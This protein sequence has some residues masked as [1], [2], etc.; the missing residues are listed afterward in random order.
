MTAL[1]GI[2]AQT[3]TSNKQ[4][5]TRLRDLH[6]SPALVLTEPA[7]FDREVETGLVLGR[8]ASMLLQRLRAAD[9]GQRLRPSSRRQTIRKHAGDRREVAD[10]AVDYAKQI[11]DRSLVGVD[12]IEICRSGQ[13]SF[14][15]LERKARCVGLP[16]GVA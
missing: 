7:A 9:L 1:V 4:L 16:Q 11:D 13:A 6:I 10:I 5:R 14:V 8:A 15:S 12:G 2:A 3:A